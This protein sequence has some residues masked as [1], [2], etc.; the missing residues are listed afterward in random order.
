MVASTSFLRRALLV[1]AVAS[2][3]S[4]VLMMAGASF[5]ESLLGLPA[6]LLRGAGLILVPFVAIVGWL[7]SRERVAASAVWAVIAMNA[8][9]VVG[10]V[11]VLASDRFDPSTLGFAFVTAQAG[12][13][14][15]FAE[16]QYVGLRKAEA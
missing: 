5:L 2:G 15:A 13:V 7:A 14:A 6:P 8:A 10:S 4:A 1:D 12:T 16:L 11:A 9:W 3:A